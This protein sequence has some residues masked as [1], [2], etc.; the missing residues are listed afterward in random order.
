MA[1]ADAMLG[2]ERTA[3]DRCPFDAGRLDVLLEEAGLDAVLAM[4]KHNVQYLLGGYRYFFYATMDAHG[5]SRYLPCFVYI[6]G[7]PDDSTYVASPMEA[8]ERDLGQFWVANTN[9]NSMTS[10]Q[11]AAAV[12]EVVRSFGPK[13]RRVGLEMSFIPLDAYEILRA[14]LPDVTFEAATLA[15]ERLRAIKTSEELAIID[16]A[17]TG[18]VDSMLAVMGRL[19]EGAT[20]IEIVEGLRYEQAARGLGFDYGLVTMGRSFNRAPSAQVWRPGEVLSL[21]SGGNVGGYIG[22]LCRMAVLGEP[23][24]ELV[25]LLA[26]IDEIQM[27]A[28]RR[29]QAGTRGGDILAEP[30]ALVARS[31]HRDYLDFVAHGM[32]I[33]SHEAPW[34]TDRT[35]VPYEARHADAPLE[36]G[37]VLSIETT[38]LHPRRGFIKLEDTV[39][40]TP[41]GWR[42]HGDAGRGWNVA[43]RRSQASPR[44]VDGAD[45]IAP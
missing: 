9:F 21:D 24:T 23:D 19:G 42:A 18:V 33:V 16:R 22:D 27:V 13:V 37:M 26:E 3:F 10:S 1:E 6:R 31:R 36:A 20:K 29:V 8:F 40:V 44:G 11:T 41:D 45:E 32:G 25:D 39:S 14:G 38:M 15:L 34:L 35:A 2:P 17:S 30:D 43:G 7:R 4:S 12:V 5:L 28:R